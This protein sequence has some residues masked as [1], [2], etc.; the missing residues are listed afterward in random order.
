MSEGVSDTNTSNVRT[1]ESDAD[2]D[3]ESVGS[4]RRS[5]RKG[6]PN[7]RYPSAKNY[8]NVVDKRDAKTRT[9]R[10]RYTLQDQLLE[11][12]A[13][14]AWEEGADQWTAENLCV[15]QHADP[16][17]GPAIGWVQSGSRPSWE[18]VTDTSPMLKALW[19]QFDSLRIQNGLLY[20]EFVD[21]KGLVVCLQLI[22]PSKLKSPFLDLIHGDLAGHFKTAKCVPHV[23]Q[24]AWWLHWRRD[25]DLY[26]RCCDKCQSYH[27]GQPPKQA[28][29]KHLN[30][31]EPC[32]RWGIDLT[33]PFPSSNGFQYMFT[34]I[35][36]F[37]RFGVC[38][39]IRNK[40]APTVAKA[41]FNE[42]FL[43][44]GFCD[45]VITDQ[46]TEFNNELLTE[47]L[48]LTGTKHLRTSGY[49]PQTN[50]AV[51]KWHKTL[52]SIFAKVIAED[53]KDWHKWVPY[54]TFCYNAATHFATG[55]SPFYVN[56][57][58]QPRWTVD[59]WLPDPNDEN[60]KTLPKYVAEVVERLDKVD[61]IVRENLKVASETSSRWY[62]Q[63]VKPRSFANGDEV[64]VFIPRRTRGRTPKWSNNYRSTGT[65]LM[66]IND[67]AYIVKIKGYKEP[68][69]VHTDK[70]KLIHHFDGSS[71]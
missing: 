56:T 12:T 51:E 10:R 52:N 25:L 36:L 8:S 64:R 27:R 17:I 67:S 66:K 31:N 65:V 9:G 38:T 60:K 11:R 20:R 50:G 40:E 59:L 23:M 34:A 15:T 22:L 68:R 35:D 44:W 57:G 71:D 47:L 49:R 21:N 29:L 63:K 6:K 18:A 3:L 69:V 58:R 5:G 1:V 53:Q 26:I 62:D 33:G 28:H 16:D 24:R 14:T 61:R 42:I 30:V 48:R 32:R 37:S 43:R 13:S 7:P 2:D 46:G 54:V 55:F 41:I 70:L 19:R 4:Q 45:E 39:P